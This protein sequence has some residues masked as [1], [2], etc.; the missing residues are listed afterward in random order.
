M[1]KARDHSAITYSAAGIGG[2]KILIIPDLDLILVATAR[3]GLLRDRGSTCFRPSR[4]E[5]VCLT[6]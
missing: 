2:Q 6:L 3:T 1:Y 5:R 4:R